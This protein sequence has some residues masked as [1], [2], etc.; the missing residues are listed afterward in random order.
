MSLLFWMQ[1][2]V[3]LHTLSP[4]ANLSRPTFQSDLAQVQGAFTE[5]LQLLN[6]KS[7]GMAA[8]EENTFCLT[9][10]VILTLKKLFPLS[11]S[12]VESGASQA[13]DD[14]V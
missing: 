11:I 2:L 14:W 3:P 7:K 12:S 8:E 1:K 4:L 10:S 9:M 6:R 5:V 13:R